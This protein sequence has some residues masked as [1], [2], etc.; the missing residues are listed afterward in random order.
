[1]QCWK[2]RKT[3]DNKDQNQISVPSGFHEN[4]VLVGVHIL[5]A[6]HSSW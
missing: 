3:L 2:E 5:A 6:N 4:M 1:M